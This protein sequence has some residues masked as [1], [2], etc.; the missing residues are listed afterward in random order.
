VHDYY[1]AIGASFG[2]VEIENGWFSEFFQLLEQY[3]FTIDESTPLDIELSIDPE[4]LG[5]IFENLLAEI[6]ETTGE[7]ARNKTGSFY[8]PR[9]IVEYMVDESIKHYL[10]EKTDISED[11]IDALIS[12][13]ENI[14]QFENGEIHKI[15]DALDNMKI[16]DPA[17]GSG[18][19]PMGIL[20]KTVNIL[21]K[22]DP[23]SELWKEKMVSKIPA[24]FRRMVR[25]KFENEGP[26]YIH[27][28]GLIEETI[29]GTDIQTIAVEI[30]KLR[31]FLSLIVE[32]TADENKTN[33]GIHPLPNLEFKFVCADALLKIEDEKNE[34]FHAMMPE[35]TELKELRELYFNSFGKEKEEIKRNFI[36]TQAK[37]IINAG[38]WHG[39]KNIELKA[40]WDPFK[41]EKAEFFDPKW[42]FGIEGFD[43]VIGNPPYIGLQKNQGILGEKYKNE[44]YQSFAKTG[45]IYALFYERG[46]QLLKDGGHL[47]FITSKQWMRAK[48]GE[49]LR[50]FFVQQTK[51]EILIDFGGYKVFDSATVD[52]NILLFQNVGARHALPKNSSQNLPKNA[53]TNNRA[54]HAMPLRAT[55]IENDFNVS[56]DI[57]EY[58]KK[59]CLEITDLSSD[60]W[61]IS[62]AD[63]YIIK[64]RIEEIGTP[65]KDWDIQIYRGVLT[66][67]NEAFIIDGATKDRL[68]AEDPKSAEILKPILRGRDIKKYKAEF[69]DLW[70]INSHNGYDSALLNVGARHALPEN[71]PENIVPENMPE[72]FKSNVGARHALPENEIA[73]PKDRARH[74]VPL[75]RIP[76]INI[77]DYPA[78]KK[79]LDQYSN[80]LEKRYDKGDTPYNL[81]NCAYLEEFEKEKIVYREISDAMNAAFIKKGVFLNN[82]L[83]MV[84]GENL[85]F[86]SALFNSSIFSRVIL[87]GTNTTGGKGDEFLKKIPI[88]QIS[89]EAQKPFETM[90]DFIL[91]A[92]E[93]GFELEANLFEQ[94]VDNMVYDLYFEE[95]MKQADC[96]ITD[97][98]KE[99]LVGAN[100]VCPD[101]IN[102]NDVQN[103]YN[104]FKTD[105]TVQRC[106]IYSRIVKEVK[107][108]NGGKE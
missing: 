84:T 95:S 102:P 54:R 59:H 78:I 33:R 32:A 106:L 80:E 41:N 90:V 25:E 97:A 67:F 72:N 17:C 63:E 99:I 52:T 101:N 89:P 4:M 108:I 64:K 49:K 91:Y 65:L 30:S 50:E 42:M 11:K 70:L 35:F 9:E 66:G 94:V 57:S 93:K 46:A 39:S 81:R 75:Q 98:V 15:I 74:A 12:W 18:A 48:Y 62:N 13:D 100:G 61:V 85:K 73:A 77:N 104:I 21:E 20:Q 27:K 26:S 19:F 5:R 10:L 1:G 23:S 87:K 44:K 36:E 96:Y 69:A 86:L 82:K 8:T 34:S 51:P 103:L 22:I 2:V 38:N 88:P 55:K 56:T 16:L 92:K 76:P 28:M 58:V 71:K 6:D 47:C 29:Y 107:I 68:I 43:V 60:S 45:D 14:L 37:L 31:V 105:K 3:N 83:Y 40:T 53:E 24:Q 7:T 79:H